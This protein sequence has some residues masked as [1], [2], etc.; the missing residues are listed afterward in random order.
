MHCIQEETQAA[1]MSVIAE[2][3]RAGDMLAV[4]FRTNKDELGRKAFGV[5]HFRRF[6]DGYAFGQEVR[7]RHGFVVVF[8]EEGTG[9]A[10]YKSEDP[11]LYRVIAA[12]A[13][14]PPS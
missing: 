6:Q 11:V 9:L 10:P 12:K 14:I 2:T 1:L 5:H 13:S 4:E 8:E 3:S 7:E